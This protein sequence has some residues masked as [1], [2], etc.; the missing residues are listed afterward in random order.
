M[1]DYSFAIPSLL[2]ISILLVFYFSLP[3]LSI[4]MN[5]VFFFALV[6]EGV[7]ITLNVV[8]SWVATDFQMYPMAVVHLLNVGYFVC[9]YLL[10]FVLFVLLASLLLVFPLKHKVL[11]ALLHVPYMVCIV[12]ACS[13]PWTKVIYYFDEAG[14]HQGVWYNS[15]YYLTYF[16]CAL[17]FVLL[18]CY[19]KHLERMRYWYSLFVFECILTAGIIVRR[20]LPSLLLYDTF[21]VMAILIVYL[22]FQNPEFHLERRTS[23]FNTTAFREY[24]EEKKGKTAHHIIGLVIYNY[25]NM[26]DVYGGKQMDMGVDMIAAYLLHEYKDCNIFYLRKGRFIL[27]T[28]WHKDVDDMIREL[29]V[30]FNYP[31]YNSEMR[32]YLTANFVRMDVKHSKESTDLLF[33]LLI[34]AMERSDTR[35][36]VEPLVISEKDMEEQ[37]KVVDLKRWLETAVNQNAVEV[38]FQPLVD[39]QSGQVVGAEALAR[40]RD[41]AGNLISP[42]DFIPIAEENGKIMILGEQVFRKTCRFLQDTQLLE[43][44]LSWVNVNL[45]PLQFMQTE[46]PQKFL[47]ITEQYGIDP[48]RIHLEITEENLVDDQFLHTQMDKMRGY[49]FR[50]ILDDYGTGYSNIT[51]LKRCP[52]LNI[53]LDMSVVWD[54]CNH[55]DEILPNMISAFRHMNFSVTAEGIEDAH[56]AGMMRDVGCDYLQGFFYTK[57]M[58]MEAFQEKYYES[59]STD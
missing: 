23:I 54:Y 59:N 8:S 52:F 57:P 35:M 32:L 24:L 41:D 29:D 55:P 13:T 47:E 50:F 56:M 18:F 25:H 46:L 21:C 34:T 28:P 22:A 44:G 37:R 20:E 27:V 15:L 5:R 16:Y 40:I 58:T 17:S 12:L 7:D 3:R 6:V 43:R 33:N 19:G 39:A 11:E 49:G 38:F 9:F 26:R 31:W 53:K 4:H 30:R 10:I 2:I 45:S 36:G 1:W 42:S 48:N 14:F 51:R